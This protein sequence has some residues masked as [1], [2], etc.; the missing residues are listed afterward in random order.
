MK[1]VLTA[2]AACLVASCAT[3]EASKKEG[4]ASGPVMEKMSIANLIPFDIA[5]CGPRA[6]ELAPL[7]TE[8]LLG[9]LLSLGPSFQECFVDA[10]SLSG[11]PVDAM[12]KAKVA[13]TVSFS[14]AGAGI[15]PA[16][17]ECLVA[18][19]KKLPL[20][21]LPAGA[22]AIEAEVP[23][24]PAVKSVVFDL[25]VASDVAGTVRLAQRS[26]CECY[27]AV[28]TAPAPLVSA[29]I[30]L[31]KEKPA[32]FT[33]EPADGS[34]LSTCVLAKLQPLKL[35]AAD[36]R[37]PL[38]FL[39]LNAYASGPTEGAPVAL[40]FQQ[41]E[42]VRSQRTADVLVAAG[43]RGAAAAAYDVVVEKYKATKKP[44]LIPE[45]RTKCAA[46]LASDDAWMGSLKSLVGVY[47]ASIK[48]VQQEKVKEA[49]WAPVEVSLTQQLAGT[50]AEL[51]KVEERRKADE[52]ACPKSR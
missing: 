31:A 25:N 43:K 5:A 29:Q 17:T 51:P 7:S 27:A 35:P 48:L 44:Q 1:R 47:E 41:Y 18:A 30:L 4:K 42:A 37:V 14:V 3:T 12:L 22:A 33:V 2:V 46:V 39:L 20:V 40:Q 8:T 19:A 45:L 32:E 50:T 23:V 16:G 11:Q 13:D 49:A 36:A 52:G 10:K 21:A 26:M 24:R 9:A 6:L 15:S 38:P 34:A 28:G